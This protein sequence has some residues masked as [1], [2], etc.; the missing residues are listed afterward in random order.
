[1]V[2]GP[3]VPVVPVLEVGVEAVVVVAGVVLL[4][5]AASAQEEPLIRPD[6]AARTLQL[7][8]YVYTRATKDPSVF[9]ITEKVPT[10]IGSA[11]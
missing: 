10:R 11:Y 4:L 6:L 8:S 7:K 2:A 3:R 9:R 1:M 5:L